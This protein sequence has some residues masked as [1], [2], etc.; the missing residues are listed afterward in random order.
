MARP[1][2]GLVGTRSS[3]KEKGMSLEWFS[4]AIVAITGSTLF[5]RFEEGTPKWR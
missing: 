4:S 5:G 3:G 2:P 1:A